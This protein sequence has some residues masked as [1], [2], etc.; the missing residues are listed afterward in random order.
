MRRRRNVTAVE[1]FAVSAG[2][3]R[4][5][6]QLG[7]FTVTDQRD[8][9]ESIARLFEAYHEPNSRLSLSRAETAPG[10]KDSERPLSARRRERGLNRGDVEGYMDGYDQFAENEV[11]WR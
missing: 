8:N 2:N 9:V 4:S 7:L 11:R 10:A 3:D 5:A 1:A 6:W